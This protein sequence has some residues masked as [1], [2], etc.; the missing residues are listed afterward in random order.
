MLSPRKDFTEV[1]LDASL[2]V[3]EGRSVWEVDDSLVEGEVLSRALDHREERRSDLLSLLSLVSRGFG[4]GVGVG[5]AA[6]C[7]LRPY[8]SEF[9]CCP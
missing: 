6:F 2:V 5:R 1:F 4:V 9:L 8:G 7:S 3:L